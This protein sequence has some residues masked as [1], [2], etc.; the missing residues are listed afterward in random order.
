MAGRRRQG[1]PLAGQWLHQPLDGAAGHRDPFPVQL[2]PHLGG[3]VD[4]ETLGVYPCDV[5]AQF[6]VATLLRRDR[7]S[8]ERVSGFPKIVPKLG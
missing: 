1:K 3:T 8:G 6:L 5:F 7:L 2:Q 4:A